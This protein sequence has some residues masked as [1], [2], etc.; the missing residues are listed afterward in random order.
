MKVAV[1]V[2]YADEFAYAGAL[3]FATWA[4]TE[5]VDIRQLRHTVPAAY[6]P[7]HFFEREL[8]CILP[9]LRACIEAHA[10]K[11]IVIDGYVDLGPSHPGLGRA[12]FEALERKV[13]II[14]VAKTAYLGAPSREVLRGESKKPLLVTSTGN[15]EMAARAIETMAG[16]YRV[17]QLLKRVDQLVRSAAKPTVAVG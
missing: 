9:L 1:D 8:P 6:R 17:P 7:G 12:L 15:L 5:S 4:D 3:V 14:G 2:Q 16:P 11:C 13:E 10:I